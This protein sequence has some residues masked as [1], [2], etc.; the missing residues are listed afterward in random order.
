M[1]KA[2]LLGFGVMQKRS[3]VKSAHPEGEWRYRGFT[4]DGQPNV[5]GIRPEAC[6]ACHRAVK[7]RDFV[8][9]YERMLVAS[10]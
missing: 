5:D 6:F 4:A 10:R 1:T 7:E 9:S 2:M 3:G 8:F